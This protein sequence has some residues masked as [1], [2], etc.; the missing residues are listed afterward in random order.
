MRVEGGQRGT[1]S[2]FCIHP[3]TFRYPVDEGHDRKANDYIGPPLFDG[4]INKEARGFKPTLGKN[5]II[6]GKC[7]PRLYIS[8]LCYRLLPCTYS[9]KFLQY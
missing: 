3:D 1:D 8:A 7:S 9:L 6:F 5:R 4:T 2:G